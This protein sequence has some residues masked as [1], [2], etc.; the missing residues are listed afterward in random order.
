MCDNIDQCSNGADEQFC[1]FVKSTS[2]PP[3][4]DAFGRYMTETE[5]YVY[6]V[7]RDIYLVYCGW[8]K[9]FQ[10]DSMLTSVSFELV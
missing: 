8:P 6:M 2:A 1:L 5:G 10:P 9:M 3:K 4:K 7:I